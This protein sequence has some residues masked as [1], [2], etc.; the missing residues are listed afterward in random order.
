[1]A[2]LTKRQ[3]TTIVNVITRWAE[4]YAG[5]R[6]VNCDRIRELV[7]IAY[8]KKT[9]QVRN[10]SR[11][12]NASWWKTVK[13][14]TPTVHFLQSPIAFDIAQAVLR[15]RLAK[16]DAKELC[17]SFS[18]NDKF[19]DTLRRDKMVTAFGNHHWYRGH[20]AVSDIW[21]QTVEP[22]VNAATSLVFDEK[23]AAE[24][25][26]PQGSMEKEL[27]R[28]EKIFA[29][30]FEDAPKVIKNVL[31]RALEN[32][33]FRD[34]VKP[35]SRTLGQKT[36]STVGNFSCS[37]AASNAQS[38]L[39]NTPWSGNADNATLN[40]CTL[41]NPVGYGHTYIDAEIIAALIGVDTD[42]DS[43][44]YELMHEAQTVMMFQSQ[45][46]VL[47]ARP[48]IH[49]NAAGELHNDEGPA[50]Q[51]A[52]GAKQYY[53]DGHALGHLGELIVERPQDLTI[54]HINNE[55]NEEIKRLAIDK[56]GWG[57]YL[58]G[59]GAT[60]LDRREN[61]V[62][63]TIEAL[64]SVQQKI[65]QRRWG[66]NST[67]EE[68]TIEQRKLILSCRSTARQYF[69]AVPEEIRN[70]V[71]GQRWMAEGA[72]TEHVAAFNHTV[73]VIGAS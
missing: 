9:V 42:A 19:L 23:A 69:L 1:M 40:R 47:A 37:N 4:T 39:T 17:H 59:V 20:S 43:W 64:V 63:N 44:P 62:D 32:N 3:K 53:I 27:R 10:K 33:D 28:L 71:E 46:L 31:L 60:L 48:T 7:K 22:Y 5:T 52:D 29:R 34:L 12:R 55:E 67:P 38:A 35:T 24:E 6:P 65:W 18:I 25:E 36:I 70:C 58:D 72:N 13:L 14:K 15:G 8:N 21:T 73:R 57:K 26:A 61:A 68:Q 50:V 11:R 2:R 66:W 56:F 45:V 16:K 49:K 30:S 41:A 51:W 54:E